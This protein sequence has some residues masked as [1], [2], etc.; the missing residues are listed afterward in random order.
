MEKDLTH[1]HHIVWLNYDGNWYI[2]P[3]E[4]MLDCQHFLHNNKT[5]TKEQLFDLVYEIICGK[6]KG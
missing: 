5:Y 6:Y 4:T 1:Y 2:T 3:F